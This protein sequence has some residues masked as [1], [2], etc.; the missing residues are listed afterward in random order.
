M[1]A[2]NAPLSEEIIEEKAK[3]AAEKFSC[4]DFTAS[5]GWFENLR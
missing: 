2:K 4:P 1:N 5:S 3:I